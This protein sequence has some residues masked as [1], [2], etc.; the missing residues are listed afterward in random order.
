[1]LS[2]IKN[3][4]FACQYS[5]YHMAFF[6]ACTRSM[7]ACLPVAAMTVPIQVWVDGQGNLCPSQRGASNDLTRFVEAEI[8]EQYRHI[9][10]CSTCRLSGVQL[11]L[12]SSEWEH[13]EGGCGNPHTSSHCYIIVWWDCLAAIVSCPTVQLQWIMILPLTL[14]PG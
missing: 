13:A 11:T 12:C 3:W 4:H 7:Q 1:M 6:H 10:N 14:W 9:M 8:V 2:D 5:S